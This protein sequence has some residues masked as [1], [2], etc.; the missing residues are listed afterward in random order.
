M[1]NKNYIRDQIKLSRLPTL[2]E[3]AEEVEYFAQIIE[4]IL[5]RNYG[6]MS[7]ISLR[8]GISLTLLDKFLDRKAAGV[9]QLDQMPKSC[10]I[11]TLQLMLSPRA[12][13]KSL[14][15]LFGA[16][17]LENQELKKLYF[18][19]F[20]NQ[21]NERLIELIQELELMRLYDYIWDKG[22]HKFFN[23]RYRVLKGVPESDLSINAIISEVGLPAVFNENLVSKNYLDYKMAEASKKIMDIKENLTLENTFKGEAAAKCDQ[24]FEMFSEYPCEFSR[25]RKVM[26][27]L[28][29]EI[30]VAEIEENGVSSLK[31]YIRSKAV[32]GAHEVALQYDF[33]CPAVAGS[34]MSHARRT[35]SNS[36]FSQAKQT[37]KGKFFLRSEVLY[38]LQ[39]PVKEGQCYRLS[40]GYVVAVIKSLD[41]EEHYL[42]GKYTSKM[43]QEFFILTCLGNFFYF[44][45]S[46]RAANQVI[47]YYFDNLSG[48]IRMTNAFK[49]MIFALP[50]VLVLAIMVG[51]L[52]YLTIG[53]YGE[54]I[55]VGGGI[56]LIGA[57]IAAKNGYDEEVTPASH[58]KIPGY[59]HRQTGKIVPTS[60]N[61]ESKSL[62]GESLEKES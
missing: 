42:Y 43:E 54:S 58:E 20:G 48:N 61:L 49:K 28:Y 36:F 37:K 55:F 59:L 53:G 2:V 25:L 10:E 40:G 6:G 1:I 5:A 18:M 35:I 13:G 23:S 31:D 44:D 51:V 8:H 17:E 38:N 16:R 26:L 34:D 33:V 45:S 57:A 24:L 29:I 4:E 7:A 47:N 30:I 21:S 27:E 41:K 46:Q 52:Y 22:L 11:A 14:V 3:G 12:E 15:N 39:S 62:D 50:L 56:M 9:F 60:L 32:I 19:I